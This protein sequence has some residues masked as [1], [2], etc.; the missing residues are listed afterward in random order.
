M[1]GL[2][3][4]DAKLYKP[5][6]SIGDC[7]NLQQ[8]LTDLD[9]WI[10]ENNLDFNESKCKVLSITRRKSPLTYAYQMN[11]NE[12]TRVHKEKDLGVLINDNLSWNNHVYAIVA[13]GNKMLGILERTCPLLT[14]NTVQCMY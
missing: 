14:N 11:S 5:I 3:A 10:R 1:A 7:E 13:K 12:I 4:D 2:Y 6:T 9:L 8:T